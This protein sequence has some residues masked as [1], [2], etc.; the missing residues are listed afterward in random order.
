M[1]GLYLCKRKKDG[2]LFWNLVAFF[3]KK[4]PVWRRRR[5]RAQDW[6]RR[7]D[8]RVCGNNLADTNGLLLY[9]L[10]ANILSDPPPCSEHTLG[11]PLEANKGLERCDVKSCNKK[12]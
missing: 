2:L 9:Y 8:G 7:R 3:V 11:K 10:H 12:V 5:R 1:M 4:D 6:D